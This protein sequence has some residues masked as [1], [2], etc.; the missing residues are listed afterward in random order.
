MASLTCA[1]ALVLSPNLAP[2]LSSL[3]VG[4]PSFRLLS[5]LVIS[6]VANTSCVGQTPVTSAGPGGAGGGGQSPASSTSYVAYLFNPSVLLT[7]IPLAAVPH[8]VLPLPLPPN[9]VHLPQVP[10]P[11]PSPSTPLPVLLLWSALLCSL[12]LLKLPTSWL[13]RCS[14]FRTLMHSFLLYPP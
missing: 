5:F 13:R 12:L 8:P 3:E 1:I 14:I 9:L 6:F 4:S 10:P 7:C 11:R 2:S